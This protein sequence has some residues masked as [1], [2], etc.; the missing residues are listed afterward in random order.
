MTSSIPGNSEFCNHAVEWLA[1]DPLNKLKNRAV[2]KITVPT[3]PSEF[4]SVEKS[5]I[6][7]GDSPFY[8]DCEDCHAG[9]AMMPTHMTVGAKMEHNAKSARGEAVP[10]E[11]QHLNAYVL[12]LHKPEAEQ[13]SESKAFRRASRLLQKRRSATIQNLNLIRASQTESSLPAL[14]TLHPSSPRHSFSNCT[15]PVSSSRLSFN[16]SVSPVSPS[17]PRS[18]FDGIGTPKS[19]HSPKSCI[20][21]GHM[22]MSGRFAAKEVHQVQQGPANE[23]KRDSLAA[24]PRGNSL[25][26]WQRRQQKLAAEI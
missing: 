1:E 26:S 8:D 3:L 21:T 9:F 5:N 11:A 24:E 2:P 4:L 13:K 19:P 22:I 10:S 20:Q 7:R 25:K 18:A 12:Q 23:Y 14:S 16:D 6:D 15:S 17:T